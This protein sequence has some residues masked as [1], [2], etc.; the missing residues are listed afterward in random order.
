M[1]A[2]GSGYMFREARHALHGISHLISWFLKTGRSAHAAQ[3]HLDLHILRFGVI[4]EQIG[5]WQAQRKQP[6]L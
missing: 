5:V 3:A 2:A 4:E 1:G 6:A